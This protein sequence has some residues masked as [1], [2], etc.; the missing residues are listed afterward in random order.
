MINPD[1]L[2]VKAGEA[3]NDALALA[4]QAGNPLVYDLH[5]LLALLSQDEWP[6]LQWRQMRLRCRSLLGDS[7]RRSRFDVLG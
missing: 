7:C 1:R 6:S 5:L 4:R 2:T 3:L